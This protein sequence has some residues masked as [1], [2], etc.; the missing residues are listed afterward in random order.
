ME[1]KALIILFVGLLIFGAHAFVAFF[2][3][4]KIP[5][6]LLLILIG[7][8]LGPITKIVSPQDFG[9]VGPVFSAIALIVILFEGGLELNLDELKKSIKSS[10]ILTVSSFF[11]TLTGISLAMHFWLGYSPALSIFIGAVLAGPAPAIIIPISKQLNITEKTKTK[12]TLESALGEALCIV[13]ALAVLQF[14]I[15]TNMEYGKITGSVIASFVF[16]LGIGFVSGFLWSVVLNKIREMK[17]AIFL[18]PS[19][20]FI[21]YGFTEILGYSG[22]VAALIFGITIGNADHL[23]FKSIVKNIKLNPI[24]HNEMEKMFFSEIVFLLKTFF[25][26]YLGISIVFSDFWTL[27]SGLVLT[28]IIFSGRFIASRISSEKGSPL[29]DNEFTYSMFAKGLATTVLASLPL[30]YGIERGEEV[31]NLVYIVILISIILAGITI[32]LAGKGYLRFLTKLFYK[33]QVQKE[34]Q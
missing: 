15:S 29:L 27:I 18:T 8:I 17:N 5:D 1:Q 10:I 28:F 23:P 20:V 6:V 9:K 7:L 21:I 4:T 19:F 2:K 33:E 12:L 32:F 26:V 25:F 24:S 34:S 16:A 31:Q 14:M 11:V 22:P 30:Q 13:G 3:K